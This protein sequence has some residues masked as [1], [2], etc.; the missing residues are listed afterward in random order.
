MD[1]IGTVIKV[2]NT[3]AVVKVMRASACGENCAM[4]KGCTQT[5]QTVKANN[6]IGAAIGDKVRLELSDQKVLLAAFFV[7]IM[8][9]VMFIIGY[10]IATWL[11]AIIGFVLPFVILKLLDKKS[12]KSY[13]ANITKIWGRN[14]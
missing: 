13:T 14:S 10:S 1:K 11:G 12:A 9:L 8:P 5:N 6:E 2:E 4:C 3:M 7:Y